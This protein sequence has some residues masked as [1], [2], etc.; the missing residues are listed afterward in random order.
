MSNKLISIIIPTRNEEKY[1]SACL[2]SVDNFRIPPGYNCEIFVIDGKSV[3]KTIQIVS[4][5][6]NINENKNIRIIENTNLIQSFALNIGINNAS[7]I[8]ILRLDA[9]CVYPVDYLEKL[10]ET[11]HRIDADNIGGLI[12]TRLGGNNF[13][14][15]IVQAITT[16]KFGVGNSGFRVGMEEGQAD[17]VPFG[18]YKKEIFNKIGL[19]DT[20]LI[21]AQDYEFNRR[22]IQSGN[23]IWLNPKINAIYFNQTSLFEFYKKQFFKE[24]PY[25]A[26]MWYLA[27]YTFAYRHAIT[28]VFTTGVIG[29]ILLSPFSLYISYPFFLVIIFYFLLALISSVQ[30]AIRFNKLS[31]IFLLPISFFLY[32]FL[33][34]MGVIWGLLQLVTNMAPVQKIKEPW[35][36]Y[37]SYR[38]KF[39]N[40]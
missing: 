38:I 29:G 19:F 15:H 33:H 14:A 26:F 2:K 40:K 39:H 13:S 37:G 35:D 6:I 5:Y 36:G 34:G 16:H 30:Q 10:I 21:R 20:R 3:D 9:H 17:T 7:G 31:H 18:F 22:I 8:R 28:S 24:A 4:E 32:H 23:K 1:I 25:N 27:P 12:T 11:S